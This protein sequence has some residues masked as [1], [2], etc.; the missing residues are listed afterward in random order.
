M[1]ADFSQ[2]NIVPVGDLVDL[3]E[4][5]ERKFCLSGSIVVVILNH[6]VADKD[7]FLSGALGQQK[8][9]DQLLVHKSRLLLAFVDPKQCRCQWLV[10]FAL[11]LALDACLILQLAKEPLGREVPTAQQVQISSS[12]IPFAPFG[13]DFVLDSVV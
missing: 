3:L 4:V 6:G 11:F 13:D 5:G 12:D 8:P 2:G 10:P 7:L 9:V 1:F